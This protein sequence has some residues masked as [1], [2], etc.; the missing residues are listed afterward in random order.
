MKYTLSIIIFIFINKEFLHDLTLY[1][2]TT[3]RIF[4]QLGTGTGLG[5]V[6]FLRAGKRGWERG[7]IDPVSIPIP[8][9]E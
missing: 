6:I 8:V 9:G 3:M 7:K 2:G 4:I 1:V 5:T